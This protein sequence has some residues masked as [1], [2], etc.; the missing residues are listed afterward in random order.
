MTVPER[1]TWDQVILIPLRDG[2]PAHLK[3]IY[4]AIEENLHNGYINPE[5]FHVNPRYGNRQR[6]THAV[7]ATMKSLEK[8][9]VVQHIGQGRT[10]VYQIT[11][12][13]AK[14]LEEIDP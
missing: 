10:G 14:Y 2:K 1:M 6:F 4:E 5:L 8:H 3:S 7:R 11:D 13:G 12:K 9:G